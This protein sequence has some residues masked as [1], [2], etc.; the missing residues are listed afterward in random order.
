MTSGNCNWGGRRMAKLNDIRM[1]DLIPPECI[2]FYAI[3]SELVC[4]YAGKPKEDH[5]FTQRGFQTLVDAAPSALI[6]SL[7]GNFPLH[8]AAFT[9][10]FAD[11]LFVFQ[12]YKKHYP[13]L[14]GALF[15]FC[16]DEYGDMTPMELALN[17]K[18]KDFK[19]MVKYLMKLMVDETVARYSNTLV[20]S[21]YMY[22][23]MKL[24]PFFLLNP[25][26]AP[27]PPLAVV[28]ASVAVSA[29]QQRQRQRRE[30]RRE[31]LRQHRRQ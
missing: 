17:R 14:V 24:D 7:D 1:G 23:L 3:M 5:Y 15:L 2:L 18:D 8:D 21:S 9:L 13:D 29:E 16:K 22:S 26:P 27:A 10:S 4:N 28:A 31:Q 19:P 12:A 30:L 11:F 20:Y 6:Q 25:A